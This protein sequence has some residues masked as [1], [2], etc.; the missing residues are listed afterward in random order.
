MKKKNYSP[1]SEIRKTLWKKWLYPHEVNQLEQFYNN[2]KK[3][4]KLYR[5]YYNDKTQKNK[6][7]FDE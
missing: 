3:D 6:K 4:R 5:D 1:L 2:L 7:Y